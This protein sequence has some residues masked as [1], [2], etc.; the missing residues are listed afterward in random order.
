MRKFLFLLEH[1]S[2]KKCK[3]DPPY[4]IVESA[5]NI[6]R[7]MRRI[8][9]TRNNM[10]KWILVHEARAVVLRLGA[11]KSQRFGEA[12]AEVRQKSK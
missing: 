2:I 1:G 12:E 7:P 11:L 3:I 9:I 6:S 8:F 4:Y 5:L 10:T